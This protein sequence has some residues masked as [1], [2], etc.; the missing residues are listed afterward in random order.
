MSRVNIESLLNIESPV[1]S[2]NITPVAPNFV[3][4]RIIG[5]QVQLGQAAQQ[6]GPSSEAAMYGALAEIAGGTAKG[7]DNF[8]K[9]TSQI[10]KSKIEKAEQ[11][12]D[13][14]DSDENLDPEAKT[15]RFDELTK[16]IYTP[17]LGD[18]WRT[19]L[20]NRKAK[21]WLSTPARNAYEETRYNRELGLFRNRP[22][23]QGSLDTPE[24][25]DRFEQEYGAKYPS[26]RENDWFK[27]TRANTVAGVSVNKG[28]RLV[29]DFK[30]LLVQMYDVPTK[31]EFS[32]FLLNQ[33]N[34]E[35]QKQFAERF[36]K[37]SELMP[38][39]TVGGGPNMVYQAIYD[40]LKGSF[41]DPEVQGRNIPPSVLEAITPEIDILITGKVSELMTLHFS[42]NVIREAQNAVTG[43]ISA[44]SAFQTTR[45]VQTYLND[46]IG[47]LSSIDAKERYSYLGSLVPSIYETLTQSPEFASLPYYKQIEKVTEELNAW[48]NT[49]TVINS[50]EIKINKAKFDQI[51]EKT[52]GS[53]TTFESWS[54]S[55]IMSL[56]AVPGSPG[57]KA[58]EGQVDQT[59]SDLDNAT[60]IIGLP[61]LTN[62]NIFIKDVETRL[63]KLLGLPNDVIAKFNSLIESEDSDLG[64]YSQ[65]SFILEFYNDLTPDQ[66]VELDRR[67]FAKGNLSLLTKV[68]S[69]YADFKYSQVGRGSAAKALTG[70]P[71]VGATNAVIFGKFFNSSDS[72]FRSTIPWLLSL[73]PNEQVTVLSTNP[74]LSRQVQLM[75]GEDRAFQGMLGERRKY[76]SEAIK[77]VEN[78]PSSPEKEQSLAYLNDTLS[79][80]PKSIPL[81][82]LDR[83]ETGYNPMGANFTTIVSPENFVVQG[84]AFLNPDNSL[85][86]SGL[87]HYMRLEYLASRF[88]QMP[89]TEEKTKFFQEFETM[90]RQ[91]GNKNFVD[92]AKENPMLI[93]GISSVL[94][95]IRSGDPSGT[96][97]SYVSGSGSELTNLLGAMIQQAASYNG[98][99]LYT[100]TPTEPTDIMRQRID[101]VGAFL[102]VA[103]SPL[104]KDGYGNMSPLVETGVPRMA[105]GSP[106]LGEIDNIQTAL[107]GVRGESKYLMPGVLTSLARE[108][109]FKGQGTEI[110]IFRDA[111]SYLVPDINIRGGAV[112][113]KTETGER[114]RKDW[115]ELNA[116]QQAQYYLTK[117][118][119]RSPDKAAPFLASWLQ[120]VVEQPEIFRDPA[121]FTATGRYLV[122]ATPMATQ[123]NRQSAN[124]RRHTENNYF[125]D[126]DGTFV[127]NSRM[128]LDAENP[129]HRREV[130]FNLAEGLRGTKA[131]VLLAPD[132]KPWYSPGKEFAVN[133]NTYLVGETTN[134]GQF[135]VESLLSQE[136]N[137]NQYKF[138]IQTLGGTPVSE[139]QFNTVVSNQTREEQNSI[140]L[141]YTP[142][143]IDFR[144]PVGFEKRTP[145]LPEILV[146]LNPQQG[147]K[148]LTG[149]DSQGSYKVNLTV[150]ENGKLFFE[151]GKE[152]YPVPDNIREVFIN[153]NKD[154]SNKEELDARRRTT[155]YLRQRWLKFQKQFKPTK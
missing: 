18:S 47:P 138:W 99:M 121:L 101:T 119:E 27:R 14:I 67:G 97:S 24:V 129:D 139:N 20:S 127:N 135:I 149:T 98:G 143:L 38:K 115:T 123:S 45:N 7:I 8:A 52:L 122:N 48:Y 10:E 57:Q 80:L 85:N 4:Q 69:K 106:R 144:K 22:E 28:K 151:I 152:A 66:K 32:E 141:F 59:V 37:F 76:I 153:P 116:E 78:Q 87:R 90:L 54:N 117:F 120:Q 86:D 133:G 84:K 21:Q 77:T 94:S 16:D 9:I 150:R 92:V 33:S 72:T 40:D 102:D 39:L 108:F 43:V 19:S 29:L 71:P 128:V 81:F 142:G 114:I 11:I 63:E 125:V 88:A 105:Y 65:Q 147:T 112:Y 131:T 110:E 61:G 41:L 109:N 12:F 93:Y 83:N 140:P 3:E 60:R 136:P 58:L 36:P 113:L 55:M 51:L 62:Q 100:V 68:L 132:N 15:D 155:E 124:V 5:G 64:F 17:V 25:I 91:L 44:S 130:L 96:F 75:Q 50:Q 34:P 154:Y 126:S 111:L 95:G 137:Y 35:I 13:Q 30:S 1:P 134:E 46:L 103:T 70:L 23:N 146:Q 145:S 89:S 53:K 42:E 26:S 82:Q 73:N 2:A 49:T 74:E 56:N 107:T 31:E 104:A 79:R 6:I 118:F 148:L